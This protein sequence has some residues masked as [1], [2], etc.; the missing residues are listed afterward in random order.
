[1]WVICVGCNTAQKR[2]L[3]PKAIGVGQEKEESEGESDST[4]TVYVC[5][6]TE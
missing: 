4:Y 6:W 2:V 3:S 5:V 1:M